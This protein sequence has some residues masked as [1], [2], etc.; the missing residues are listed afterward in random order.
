MG[1]PMRILRR[2]RRLTITL[3]CAT[4]AIGSIWILLAAFVGCVE[5]CV[6]NVDYS[7]KLAK[8]ALQ[9][10]EACGQANRGF[11]RPG[12]L[13]TKAGLFERGF[14]KP[15]T[16][17]DPYHRGRVSITV[18]GPDT[19]RIVATTR[20]TVPDEGMLFWR[21]IPYTATYEILRTK[22]GLEVTCKPATGCASE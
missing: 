20:L 22:G 2:R 18:L 13:C 15:G 9:S 16:M 21:R 5:R 1:G 19:Y 3:A 4:I 12:R 17:R 10:M 6:E 11:D 7:R 14:A 8:G